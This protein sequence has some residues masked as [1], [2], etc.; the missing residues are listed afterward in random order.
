MDKWHNYFMKSACNAAE[1]SKDP[2][3]KV[4]A[5]IVSNRQIKSTGFNGAPKNFPD[6]LVPTTNDGETLIEKK[7][8]FMCHAELNAILNY[9]GRIADLKNADVYVTVSPCSHCACMLSQVGIKNVIYKEK[10]HR[11]EETDA[12]EYIFKT[13]GVNLIPFDSLEDEDK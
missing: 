13:C 3:T 1:L 8:T 2:N 11:K 5:I 12:A 6:E 9:D 4:G 7:N 10:Y